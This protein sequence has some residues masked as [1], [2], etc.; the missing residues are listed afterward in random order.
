MSCWPI[1]TDFNNPTYAHTARP[2]SGGEPEQKSIVYRNK[3]V[4]KIP[5]ECFYSVSFVKCE[6][7]LNILMRCRT[8]ILILAE[9]EVVD[10]D[11]LLINILGISLEQI[12]VKSLRAPEALFNCLRVAPNVRKVVIRN[13][14][15]LSSSAMETI[16]RS[17]PNIRELYANI[18]ELD[19]KSLDIIKRMETFVCKA[20]TG[21]NEASDQYRFYVLALV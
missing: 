5:E 12:A 3:R 4:T 21:D 16:V 15:S 10:S 18:V 2:T 6:I 19:D 13:V 8:R 17:F 1:H 7:S 20:C 11:E 14:V 9:C